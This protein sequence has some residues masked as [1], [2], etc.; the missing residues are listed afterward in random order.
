MSPF[1]SAEDDHD[2]AF[3]SP[4]PLLVLDFDGTV[5]LGDGPVHAYADAA[6]R[7]LPART[8]APLLTT[9][10]RF[11]NSAPGSRAYPDGYAAVADLFGAY[12]P[13]DQLSAAFTESRQRLA[14][15]EV[16]ITA[17]PGLARFLDGLTGRALRVLVTNAPHVGVLESLRTL[18][19]Q[20]HVDVVR[21]DASKPHGF[22]T[23]LP[24]MLRHRAPRR[25][26]SVGDIWEND[27][28]LP[29]EAG[30]ATAYIDRFNHQSGPSTLRGPDF[31]AL[32]PAIQAWADNPDGF[33]EGHRVTASAM[34]AG[35]A[36]KATHA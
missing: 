17:P 27:L 35:G 15:G 23:L 13:Q 26:L 31:P 18:G 34:A 6:A 33:H 36:S 3:D 30:C 21:A 24:L 4:L 28:R 22:A 5:C 32:Y 10:Q 12:L 11:L 25:L 9:L 29:L 14:A 20:D 8:S 1:P 19:L 16:A 2:T 7:R